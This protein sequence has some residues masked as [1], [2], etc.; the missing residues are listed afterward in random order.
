M[1]N[2]LILLLIAGL[3]AC[4]LFGAEVVETPT[5]K[6]N[7]GDGTATTEYQVRE[8][9]DTADTADDVILI[10]GPQIVLAVADHPELQTALGVIIAAITQDAYVKGHATPPDDW[11]APEPEPDPEDEGEPE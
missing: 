8:D 2:K 5:I 6:I 4:P 11:V 7:I 1:K 9:N 3:L 10:H